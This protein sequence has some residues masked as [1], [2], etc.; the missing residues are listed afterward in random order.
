M[1]EDRFP[2]DRKHE[3]RRSRQRAEVRPEPEPGFGSLRRGV[4]NANA[5]ALAVPFAL[6]GG[7]PELR[8][9]AAALFPHGG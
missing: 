9:E 8:R 3:I 7:W 1:A 6:P 2:P 4:L 5:P